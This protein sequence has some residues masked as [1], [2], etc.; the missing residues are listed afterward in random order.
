MVLCM[1][2]LCAS[3]LGV[4]GGGS[5]IEHRCFSKEGDTYLIVLS[6]LLDYGFIISS[7]EREEPMIVSS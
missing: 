3:S 1:Q 4:L 5:K 7:L 2:R 6:T